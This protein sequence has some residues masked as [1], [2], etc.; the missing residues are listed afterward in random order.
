[1]KEYQHCG[2]CPSHYGWCKVGTN[3]LEKHNL[4]F[5]WD[6]R[7]LSIDDWKNKNYF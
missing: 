2:K 6:G 7:T 4:K 5:H 3:Q 1:M